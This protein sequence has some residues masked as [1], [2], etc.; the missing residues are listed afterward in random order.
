MGTVEEI[1][2]KI[3]ALDA[4][5]AVAPY[6]WGVKPRGVAF[7]YFCNC[8]PGEQPQLKA[9]LYLL[10]GWNTFHD[11]VQLRVSSDFGYYSSPVEMPHFE[12]VFLADGSLKAFRHETGYVPREPNESESALLARLLWEVY[13]VMLRIESDPKL[14]L[15]YSDDRAVFARVESADGV[16]HD[17]PLAI[18]ERPVF[19]ERVSFQKS[20]VEA[21]KGLPLVA[22]E[23][24]ELDFR[25]RPDLSTREVRPRFGYELVAADAKTG[26][27]IVCERTSVDPEKGLKHLWESVPPRVLLLFEKRGRVPGEVRV[28]SGRLFR[29][30]RSLGAE[31]PFK[32]SLHSQLSYCS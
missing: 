28:R 7:P 3:A 17:A 29:L 12:I 18:P 23:A 4:W 19:V 10:D 26:E 13:G 5:K 14:P 2:R 31:L 25:L 21:V 30:M 22:E 11:W 27:R 6:N 20:K 24:I 16:W 9:R 15:V 8:Q 32:L 1:G